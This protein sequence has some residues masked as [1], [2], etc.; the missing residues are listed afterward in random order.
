MSNTFTIASSPHITSRDTTRSIML[1]VIIALLPAFALSVFFFGY[2]SAVVVAVCTAACVGFEALWC[3]LMKKPQSI[4]DLSAV[5]TG[6][7][8]AFN[9]PAGIPLWQAV[10][11][12]LVAIVVVKQLFGG[13]GCNF[14]NPALAGRVVMAVSFTS[15]MLSYSYPVSTLTGALPDVL[16]GATPLAALAGES[17]G[18]VSALSLFLGEHGGVLGETSCA[19]LLLGGIYLCAKKVIKP[20]I[21]LAYIGSTFLFSWMFGNEHP[22]MFI[23]SGGLFLGAI[24]MATDYVTSPYTDKGKWIFGIGCGLLT[25][26]IRMFAGEGNGEG[27]SFSILLM[28]LLVPYINGWCRKKPYGTEAVRD[29][30]R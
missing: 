12:S 14:V 6:M 17:S 8:L 9:L 28:N 25:T 26:V 20:I 27:V 7:L 23:L 24:F 21:P 22:L 4:G 18:S 11:G 10:V 5:V 1:D 30:A 3:L 16:T 13:I 29:E 19:A 15:A 2:R